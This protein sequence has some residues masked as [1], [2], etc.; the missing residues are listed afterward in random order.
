MTYEEKRAYKEKLVQNCMTYCRIDYDDDRDILET[1]VDAVIQELEELVPGFDPYA[2]TAR[3]RLL[4]YFSVKDLYDN[5]DKYQKGEVT[6]VV[7][8]AVSSMLLKE[9]Y[10]GSMG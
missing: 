3:K 10:G 7:S 6:T 2:L 9:M 1:M 8:R 5:R 4:V